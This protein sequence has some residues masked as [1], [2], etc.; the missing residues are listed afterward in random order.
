MWLES[1]RGVWGLEGKRAV[2]GVMELAP[3]TIVIVLHSVKRAA[4]QD[5]EHRTDIT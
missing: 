3:E 2:R 4:L 1:A 5:F